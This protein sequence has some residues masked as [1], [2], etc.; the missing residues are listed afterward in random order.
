MNFIL[1]RDKIRIDVLFQTKFSYFGFQ[2]HP[3]GDQDL[4]LQI[5]EINQNN[6]FQRYLVICLSFSS[7]LANLGHWDI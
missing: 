3:K 4:G 2:Q 1:G 7:F 5:F 6:N